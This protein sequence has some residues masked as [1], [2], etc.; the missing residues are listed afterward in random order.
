MKVS[1]VGTAGIPAN[2]GGFETLVQNLSEFHHRYQIDTELV[3]YC[4]G[5]NYEERTLRYL[6]T[7]LKY[8]PLRANGIWSIP[9]D[10][11]SILKAVLN[12]SDTILVLGVSGAIALPLLRRLS[13]VRVVTNIDGIEWRR[14]KWQG[15]SRWFLRVSERIAVT[16]SDVVIADN[17]SICTYVQSAY[18]VSPSVIA[19][20]GDHAVHAVGLYK[21]SQSLPVDYA[22]AVCRIE[23]EN[24]IHIILKAFSD[25]PNF[26]LVLVG[27]WDKSD[28]G[29]R[30][31]LMYGEKNNIYLFDPIYDSS[32]L[33]Y[34]R[35]NAKV[36]VHGH[37]A[38]GTN[39]SLV[40][41]MHFGKA[42]FAY[43]CDFNR[44]T[45]ENHGLYFK[46]EVALRRLLS[47]WCHDKVT[48][49]GEKMKEIAKRRYTW[50]VVARSYFDLLMERPAV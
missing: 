36:Y 48:S 13:S 7:E 46:D 22:F 40:E 10:I 8:I 25:E 19:Y 3:V 47:D 20:G 43:D 50:E 37:S 28:Y 41:A 9:Y 18:G 23:P 4:S 30:L 26:P 44:S 31:K 27:N 33:K 16:Y 42:I 17:S 15:I 29:Q 5:N 39:P 45:T 49:I 35:E 38:G 11:L 1:I 2:Y 6:N 34:L 21:Y 24:N 12:R 14:E 32:T